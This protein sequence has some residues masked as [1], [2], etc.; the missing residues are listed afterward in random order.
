MFEVLFHRNPRSLHVPVVRRLVA[1]APARPHWKD[2]WIA[3]WNGAG[4][5]VAS[6]LHHVSNWT[7]C[8]ERHVESRGRPTMFDSVRELQFDVD[9]MALFVSI[10]SLTVD[11]S[12]LTQSLPWCCRCLLFR[13]SACP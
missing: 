11:L 9:G 6:A 2:G 4:V 8:F 5:H 1:L 7:L 3:G 12:T 13:S 10:L